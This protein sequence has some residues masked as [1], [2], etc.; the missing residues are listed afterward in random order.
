MY[1][2]SSSKPSQS[3]SIYTTFNRKK[4]EQQNSEFNSM[5]VFEPKTKENRQRSHTRKDL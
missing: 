3:E 4:E 1:N 5:E 2:I